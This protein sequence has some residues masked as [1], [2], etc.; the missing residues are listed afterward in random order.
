MLLEPALAL[1]EFASIAIGVLAGD[2]MVKQSPVEVTYAGTV[3]PGKYLVLVGGDI[4]SVEEAFLR[5]REIGS[6]FLLDEVFLPGVHS[7]VVASLKGCRKPAHGDAI[8]VVETLTVASLLG[9]A[10]V[11]VKGADVSLLEIRIADRLGGK[12]YCVFS[13]SLSAVEA[14][15]DLAEASI[16]NP[17]HLVARVVIPQVHEEMRSN[18]NAAPDFSSRLASIDGG[19]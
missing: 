18:L 16:V 11:G 13:G 19:A 4:A 8:G 14:A 10:D 6:A 5:G 2:A 9:A 15:V 1:L 3:H 17:A 7:E 12:A